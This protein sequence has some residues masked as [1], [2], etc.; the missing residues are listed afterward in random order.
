MTWYHPS[1][2]A[3]RQQAGVGDQTDECTNGT[4]G[5]P[6]PNADVGELPCLECLAGADAGREVATDGGEK[7]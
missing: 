3:V 6:G 7:Q 1:A 2:D 4:E 5:C